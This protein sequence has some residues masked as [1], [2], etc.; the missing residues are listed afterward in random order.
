MKHSLQPGL[1]KVHRIVVD[2]DR[3]ISFMGEE[4]PGLCHP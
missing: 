3:T 4:A 1:S 2:R